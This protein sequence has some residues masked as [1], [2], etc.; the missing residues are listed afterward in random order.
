M[1]QKDL[2]SKNRTVYICNFAAK[3]PKT[4]SCPQFSEDKFEMPEW[5]GIL[6]ASLKSAREA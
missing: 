2:S 5:H 4:I 3:K 6:N 1:K